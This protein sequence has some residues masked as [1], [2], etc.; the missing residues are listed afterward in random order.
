MRRMWT[1][2]AW[3]TSRVVHV[4]QCW[5]MWLSLG[6]LHGCMMQVRVV[7]EFDIPGGGHSRGPC[8]A[9]SDAHTAAGHKSALLTERSRLPSRYETE[10]GGYS[11]SD[12]RVSAPRIGGRCFRIYCPRSRK[13]PHPV[14]LYVAN[15]TAIAATSDVGRLARECQRLHGR[16]ERWCHTGSTS[17]TGRLSKE[18]V[19][20]LPRACKA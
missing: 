1:T 14:P 5:T 20:C 15:T 12:G 3:G 18:R 11:A 6:S 8:I 16:E 10:R 17:G 7:P 13:P 2:A 9:A 19:G 4:G